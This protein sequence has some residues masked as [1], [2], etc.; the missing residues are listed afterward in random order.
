MLQSCGLNLSI[1][2]HKDVV[3]TSVTDIDKKRIH[4]RDES[5]DP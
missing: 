2:S 4:G 3:F 5:N 1:V